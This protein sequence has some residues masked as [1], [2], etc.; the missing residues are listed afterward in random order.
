[1][2][3]FEEAIDLLEK[4]GWRQGGDG[5]RRVGFCVRGALLEVCKPAGDNYVEAYHCFKGVVKS[6][7][8][9]SWNDTSSRTEDQVIEALRQASKDWARTHPVA[10]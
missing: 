5:N 8:A 6:K 1:M 3:P 4:Y 9:T 2:N 10:A 7:S